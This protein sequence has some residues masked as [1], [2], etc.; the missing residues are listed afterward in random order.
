MLSI[1]QMSTRPG[2]IAPRSVC[3]NQ[4]HSKPRAAVATRWLT[5]AARSHTGAHVCWSGLHGSPRQLCDGEATCY[6]WAGDATCVPACQAPATCPSLMRPPVLRARIAC[7]PSHVPQA[8]CP[9]AADPHLHVGMVG[10]PTTTQVRRYRCERMCV[11]HALQAHKA[12]AAIKFAP[13]VNQTGQVQA[14]MK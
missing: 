2:R 5:A 8:C 1:N 3:I 6:K 12:A 10:H 7:P 13:Q 4:G 14:G 11:A 9:T